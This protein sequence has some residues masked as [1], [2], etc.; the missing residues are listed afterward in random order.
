MGHARAIST[1][2]CEPA[3][4]CM[5][6]GS[7]QPVSYNREWMLGQNSVLLIDQSLKSV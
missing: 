6:G 2:V 3:V 7:Q 5:L 4:L 1:I